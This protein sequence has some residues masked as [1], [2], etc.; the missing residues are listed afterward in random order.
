MW[1]NWL[2][3]PAITHVASILVPLAAIGLV[4]ALVARP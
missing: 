2:I 4:H 1:R 3:F